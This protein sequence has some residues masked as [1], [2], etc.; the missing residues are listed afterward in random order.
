M[1]MKKPNENGK[2]EGQQ[3][4]SISEIAERWRCSEGTVYNRLRA[5]GA[6]VLDFSTGG[7]RGKKVVSLNTILEIEKQN[8]TRL[9]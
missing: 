7:R 8:T 1:T 6:S 5:V 9:A 2:S 3:Y 4:L